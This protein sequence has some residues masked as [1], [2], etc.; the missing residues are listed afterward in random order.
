MN[1]KETEKF[2]IRLI[3]ISSIIRIFLSFYLELGNDEVYYWTYSQNLQWNYFD[4][5]PFI[6]WVIRAFTLNL[7]LQN[8]EGFLRL[9]SIVCTGFSTY[10][11][12]R[13]CTEIHNS[14]A[15]LLAALLYT[16][17]LYS[18][19][20]AGFFIMPDSPQM[21][22]WTLSL[23]CLIGILRDEKSWK[24]WLGFG[25]FS[26]LC[27][28]SKVHGVFLWFGLG[29]FILFHRRAF[30][31]LSQLY[32]AF[33]ICLLIISPILV[34][35][36]Q[37]HF[38]TYRFHSER[39]KIDGLGISPL[40]FLREMVGQIGYNNPII[41]AFSV[42]AL[43]KFRN[44]L[45][46][47]FIPEALRLFNFIALPMILMVLGIS[48]FRVTL[49][50]WAG[51]G[52]ICLIPL[53]S[54]YFDEKWHSPFIPGGIKWAI[55]ILP[56]F[57]TVAVLFVKF[58]PGTLNPE[59]NLSEVFH[60]SLGLDDIT[61]DLSGWKDSG[62]AFQK[63]MGEEIKKEGF[64]S[65]PPLIVDN[66]FAGSHLDYYYAHPMGMPVIGL[67]KERNLHQF[68]WSNTLE[69]EKRI[70]LE[71]AYTVVL[72]NSPIDPVKSYQAYYR[73]IDFLACIHSYR[74]NRVTGYKAARN[75]YIYRLS[76]FKGFIPHIE[77]GELRG[78]PPG[79]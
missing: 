27:I 33:F 1:T 59:R 5:P 47:V 71:T 70:N 38:I 58:Y 57:I 36:I 29:L 11:I 37:N 68:V 53:V 16:A 49:P 46:K 24:S 67:G 64:L 55:W 43:F 18:S 61:L 69:M 26:G 35:N 44:H 8:W 72:S 34:W 25:L 42:L 3:L 9:G 4:H 51:P 30:F 15:G 62:M 65:K 32:I 45:S 6:A 28:L 74:G 50:H 23:W 10:F 31:R 14:R 41:V 39:I 40:N 73:H 76:G 63:I 77:G 79:F 75:F 7:R 22:F 78:L 12:Y 66:W 20:I 60:D 54:V 19:V 2:L 48:L 52:Y 56:S 17:S 21:V 13:I